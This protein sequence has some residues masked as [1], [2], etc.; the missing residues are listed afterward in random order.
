[1]AENTKS[2]WTS[3][4]G[5]ILAAAGSAVGLGNIWRFPYQAATGGGGLFLLIYIILVFT[6]GYALLTT[7]IAMGRKT[8]KPC[9][10]TFD[11]ISKETGKNFKFL[12]YTAYF[13]PFVIY[14]YYQVIGGW[15]TWYFLQYLTFHMQE[16]AGDGFFTGFITHQYAPIFYTM[17]YTAVTMFIVYKGVEKGVEKFCKY[18]MPVLFMLV[19]FIAFYAITLKGPSGTGVQGLKIYLVPSIKGISFTKFLNIVMSAIAQMFYSL[20]LA[21]GIMITYGSYCKK[22]VNI[23]KS[24]G[25][26]AFFDTFVAFFA[27]MMIIPTVYAFNGSEGLSSAGP[28]LIFVTLPKIFNAMGSFGV[29]FGILFFALVL[30]AALTSSMSLLETVVSDTM[31]RFKM[32]REKTVVRVSLIEFLLSVIVCLGYTVW[33]FELSLPV[34]KA[35]ILDLFDYVTNNVLMPL[36]AIGICIVIGWVLKPTWVENEIESQGKVFKF[37]NFYFVLV[38]YFIPVVLF[39]LFLNTNGVFKLF[40]K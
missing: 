22:D 27:G 13:I 40:T 31:E 12:G 38:K 33:Y 34:G 23:S 20:S 32:P 10:G 4:L 2:S 36:L 18:V 28:G 11:D 14:S 8:G 9:M 15:V 30:F 7:E 6:V 35:Q 21:M 37:K 39:I 5:F 24:V 1:M 25:R 17:L 26:I 16:T 19:I 3:Q 29:V